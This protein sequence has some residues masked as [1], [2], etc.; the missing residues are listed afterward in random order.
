MMSKFVRE[1]RHRHAQSLK[2]FTISYYNNS[3]KGNK[4]GQTREEIT[5]S[6]GESSEVG[7]QVRTPQKIVDL[8]EKITIH[9]FVDIKAMNNAASL[10][11]VNKVYAE[12]IVKEIS[13]IHNSDIL[14]TIYRSYV[15]NL[16][17]ISSL[18]SHKFVADLKSIIRG[19]NTKTKFFK[20]A[21]LELLEYSIKKAKIDKDYK[22]LTQQSKYAYLNFII[23]YL[24]WSLK[25]FVCKR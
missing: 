22:K 8:V 1:C 18:C 19:K 6:E 15:S 3:E 23:F 11:S 5:N 17:D 24:C 25:N 21:S 14:L 12:K 16:K 4:I 9:R 2:S 13:N 20:Q 7:G 10:N